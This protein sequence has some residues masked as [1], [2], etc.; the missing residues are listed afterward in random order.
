[1]N[2]NV[3]RKGFINT[4]VFPTQISSC[5]QTFFSDTHPYRCTQSIRGFIFLAKLL[6]LSY[7]LRHFLPLRFSAFCYAETGEVEAIWE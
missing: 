6:L 5:H 1:M 4:S 2:M 3:M 7:P